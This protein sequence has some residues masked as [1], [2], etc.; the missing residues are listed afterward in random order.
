MQMHNHRDTQTKVFDRR[1]FITGSLAVAAGALG[2]GAALTATPPN[3]FAASPVEAAAAATTDFLPEAQ[4]I[5]PLDKPA[6]SDEEA[7]VGIIGSGGAALAAALYLS[8]NNTKVLLVEKNPAWG[9]VT[10]TASAW[11]CPGGTRAHAERFGITEWDVDAQLETFLAYQAYPATGSQRALVRKTL[12]R[13]PQ[14]FDWFIDAGGPMFLAGPGT[15]VSMNPDKST[16]AVNAVNFAVTKAQELGADLRLRTE[17]TGIVADGGRAVGIRVSDLE[18]LEDY[19]IGARQAVLL[20]AGGFTSNIDMLKRW[21]PTVVNTVKTTAAYPGDNGAVT[22]MAQGL[23]ANMV[24]W[25]SFFAFDGGL[26][27]DEWNHRIRDGDVQV[28]RQPWLGIDKTGQRYPFTS[29]HDPINPL[30]NA[31]Y[32]QAQTLQGLPD[33]WGYVFWDSKWLEHTLAYAEAG[34][35]AGETPE[36]TLRGQITAI[37]PDSWTDGVERAVKR[38][39]IKTAD[40]IKEVATALGIDPEVAQTA[41]DKWN[42]LCAEGVDKEFNY[43]TQWLQPL[44]SPPFYAAKVGSNLLST[45][46]GVQINPEMKVIDINGKVIEGLFAASTTIGGM[47]GNSSN[48]SG[49]ASPFGSV[50]LTWITGYMAAQGILGQTYQA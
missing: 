40:S 35:R 47:I 10:A 50:A 2:A 18:T 33:S 49:K 9:G 34:C 22:R 39:T 6:A 31:F 3:A 1:S 24:G 44:D 48:G 13:G 8:Q 29:S 20:A 4:P 14:F 12:E 16:R 43:E 30:W 37:D 23:G 36:N 5:N 7:D 46:C 28:A 11:L 45:Q 15:Y 21:C 38:G 26:D 27:V 25:D 42:A 41:A 32:Q 17:C 19:F